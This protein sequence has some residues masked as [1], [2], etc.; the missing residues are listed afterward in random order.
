M[1]IKDV[2]F[3]SLN[4]VGATGGDLTMKGYFVLPDNHTGSLGAVPAI[5][6]LH[7]LA[8]DIAAESTG[9][10]GLIAGDVVAA[11]PEAIRRVGK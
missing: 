9:P 2:S 1:T 5:V 6:L 10:T 4:F 3:T 8:G 11:L 7:G